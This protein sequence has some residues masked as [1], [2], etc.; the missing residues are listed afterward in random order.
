MIA[1]ESQDADWAAAA[2]S[3]EGEGG[4]SGQDKKTL[5]DSDA[6]EVV[7]VSPASPL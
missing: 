5:M 7:W 3:D 1:H 4:H 2:S 6:D